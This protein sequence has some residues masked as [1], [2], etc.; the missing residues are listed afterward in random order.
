MW[1]RGSSN[2][3]LL[4]HCAGAPA[5]WRGHVDAVSCL[6]AAAALVYPRCGED[7][8][9]HSCLYAAAALVYPRCGEDTLMHSLLSPASMVQLR[10]FSGPGAPPNCFEPLRSTHRLHD[11]A[12]LHAWPPCDLFGS[13][14]VW[15]CTSCCGTVSAHELLWSG[16]CA[17]AAVVRSV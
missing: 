17:Q 4:Q 2:E 9:M 5:L 10:R 3:T 12:I 16:Q 6:D 7:M 1:K 15:V 11:A 8:L 13:A 14:V